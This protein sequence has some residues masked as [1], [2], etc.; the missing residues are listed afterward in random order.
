MTAP[1]FL[2]YLSQDEEGELLRRCK[3]KKGSR[4]NSG[5]S[6][7]IM[8]ATGIALTIDIGLRKE[9][10]LAADWT[11]I[12]LQRNEWTVPKRLAKSG[13]P[14]SIPILPRSQKILASLPRSD[15]IK[16]VLWHDDNGLHRRYFDLLPML[17]EIAS[18]GRTYIFRR[19]ITKLKQKGLK[20]T[21]A[22]RAEIAELREREAWANPIPDLIW[23]DLR[24]TCGCRLLEAVHDASVR[25]C[26]QWRQ[27]K[28]VCHALRSKPTS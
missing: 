2:R 9:E 14:R 17:Q 19:E 23:H 25:T 20:L 24:R 16:S 1:P 28:G 27:G 12:D 5:R 3:G 4:D 6:D 21:A 15:Q 22:R 13:R 26:R 7:H 8:L 18:G 11:M 10:L